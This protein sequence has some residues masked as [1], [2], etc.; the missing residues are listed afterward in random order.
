MKHRG[1][2]IATAVFILLLSTATHTTYSTE[3]GTGIHSTEGPVSIASGYGNLPL[4]FEP[5][6]GQF[7]PLF[8]FGSERAG[9]A[10][11]LNATVATFRFHTTTEPKPVDL[12]IRFRGANKGASIHAADPLPGVANY[13][14]GKSENWITRVPTYERVVAENI[15]PGIDTV[16]Y[17]NQSRFEYDFIVKPGASPEQIEVL[18]VDE[19]IR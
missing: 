2:A 1:L 16:Y 14:Y 17:G 3:H 15:Y 8:K 18:P 5:N 4:S 11:L 10:L 6:R 19:S 13:Y 12:S 9:Y 7:E